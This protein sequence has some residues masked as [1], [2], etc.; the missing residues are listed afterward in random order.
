MNT[1]AKI[2]A[3]MG[4]LIIV[5]FVGILGIAEAHGMMSGSTTRTGS[6]M[7][8]TM[9]SNGNMSAEIGSLCQNGQG[10]MGMMNDSGNCQNGQDMQASMTRNADGTWKCPINQNKQGPVVV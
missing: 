1:I 8:G 9:D 5:S 6:H 10:H 2:T 4:V 7:S 3:V